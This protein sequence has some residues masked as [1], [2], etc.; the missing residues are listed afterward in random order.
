MEGRLSDGVVAIAV[1]TYA[2]VS[3]GC[4]CAGGTIVLHNCTRDCPA[5]T[6]EPR[7]HRRETTTTNR[8]SNGRRNVAHCYARGLRRLTSATFPSRFK[9]TLSPRLASLRLALPLLFAKRYYVTLLMHTAY[10]NYREDAKNFFFSS[11]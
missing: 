3:R 11:V 5:T 1:R 2:R 8:I 10:S 9:Q 7:E 4:L 6:S